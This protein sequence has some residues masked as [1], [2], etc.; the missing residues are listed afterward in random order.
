MHEWGFILWDSF[1]HISVGVRDAIH[2]VSFFIVVF[3][4]FWSLMTH[5]VYRLILLNVLPHSIR[6][7]GGLPGLLLIDINGALHIFS[8]SINFHS[9]PSFSF[10]PFPPCSSRVFIL[11]FLLYY[12][13]HFCVFGP[14]FLLCSA[15]SFLGSLSL[16]YAVNLFQRS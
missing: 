13:H 4:I 16:S 3:T 10:L 9:H 15:F 2:R 1:F 11:L 7:I 8:S 6:F 5:F 14:L 12:P